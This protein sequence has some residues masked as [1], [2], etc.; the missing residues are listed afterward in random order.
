MDSYY[1]DDQNSWLNCT[2]IRDGE[3]LCNGTTYHRDAEGFDIKPGSAKFYEYVGICIALVS[4]AGIFS[5][6]TL[7]LLSLDTLNLQVL[8]RG[9]DEKSKKYA[10][11]LMPIVKHHH[12]LLVTLLLS[13]AGVAETLPL[14]LD[15]LVPS[16]VYAILISV[17]A[18]L[19]FGEVLPQAIC[20]RHGL[21]IGYYLSWFVRL[22]MLVLLPVGYPIAK[23]LDFFLGHERGA[24]F[25]RNE[26]SALVGFHKEEADGIEEPL[27]DDEITIIQG[28]LSMTTKCVADAMTPLNCVY[29]LSTQ[30]KLDNSTMTEILQH[31][32]SRIP[33]YTRKREDAKQFVLVKNLIKFDPDDAQCI[34]DAPSTPLYCVCRSG[35]LYDV[36]NRFQI[37]AA[38]VA[39]VTDPDTGELLGIITLEDVIEELIQEEIIDETD[40]FTDVERKSLIS[41]RVRRTLSTS[42]MIRKVASLPS[43]IQGQRRSTDAN[44]PDSSPGSD[45]HLSV[46]PT[47]H[48]AINS[49]VHVVI[50]DDEDESP[51]LMPSERDSLLKK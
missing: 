1:E 26:L 15:K 25:R 39:G 24:Y 28:A 2:I 46:S 17:T 30:A 34:T 50:S 20:S 48:H 27:T 47:S 23:L 11:T 21:A 37:G 36:L 42:G 6:L 35:S 4:F 32:H 49:S 14:F 38:H 13:N 5:G 22:L 43:R 44:M 10:A 31:G 7:G 16:P 40:V 51:G 12:L 18:V 19:I 29:M 41:D 3:I 9:G 45:N 33:L 8:M